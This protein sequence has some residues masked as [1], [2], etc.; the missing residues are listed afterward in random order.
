MGK[1]T[2][3]MAIF[4]SYVKLPEGKPSNESSKVVLVTS[5]HGSCAK[6]A[7]IIANQPDTLQEIKFL[8][9]ERR[10]SYCKRLFRISFYPSLFTATY[11]RIK[12]PIQLVDLVIFAMVKLHCHVMYKLLGKS[13]IGITIGRMMTHH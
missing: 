7:V 6:P 2:I 11:S 4:N 10:Y 3:S 8:A 1:S 12:L 5:I 9:G 13:T